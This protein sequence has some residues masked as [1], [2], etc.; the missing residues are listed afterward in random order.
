MVNEARRRNTL[1]DVTK[2]ARFPIL[3]IIMPRRGHPTTEIKYGV[4]YQ[5]D[6]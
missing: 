1:D 3:S 5:K 4:A 6:A 2:I